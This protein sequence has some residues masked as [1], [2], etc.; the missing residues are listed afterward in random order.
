MAVPVEIEP[1]SIA[2]A[3]AGMMDQVGPSLQRCR[4]H[5]MFSSPPRTGSEDADG[6]ARPTDRPRLWIS[7]RNA[8]GK[9]HDCA[10]SVQQRTEPSD[11][12][13]YGAEPLG[14][15]LQGGA[16]ARQINLLLPQRRRGEA[17]AAWRPTYPET[18]LAFNAPRCEPNATGCA[19]LWRRDPRSPG[20]TIVLVAADEATCRAWAARQGV[21]ARCPRSRFPA[22][23]DACRWIWARMSRGLISDD[24]LAAKLARLRNRIAEA[25]RAFDHS[26]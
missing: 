24:D 3:T 5:D 9:L 25:S 15:A 17:Q 21:P 26:R 14:R 8:A 11:A 18:L 19:L 16:D 12:S 22:F 13:L 7:V 10:R 2:D 20:R 23:S 1:A 6:L 4:R